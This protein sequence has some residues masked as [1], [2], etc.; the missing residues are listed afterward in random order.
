ME[1]T[2]ISRNSFV[3]QKPGSDETRIMYSRS[4]CEEI[5]SRSETEAV[6]ENLIM[7]L[8][9]KDQDNLQNKMKGS[10]FIFNGVNY[11]YYDLIE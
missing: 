2:I 6:A 9:Q 1:I 3:P 7:Q 8:L 5:M 11:L 4:F 10:D